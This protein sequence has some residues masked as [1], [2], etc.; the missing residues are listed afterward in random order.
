M[1]DWAL[2]LSSYDIHF[3]SQKSM[4]GQVIA[5]FLAEHPIFK[6]SKIPED[7]PDEATKVNTISREQTWQLLFDGV[8]RRSTAGWG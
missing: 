4:K 7:I 1:V 3:V 5:N 6:N 2:L 8:A